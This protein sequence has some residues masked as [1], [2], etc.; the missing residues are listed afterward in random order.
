MRI[1]FGPFAFDPQ[2]RLLWREGVEIALPPRVLGVLEVLLERAG[3]VVA[4]QDLL[5]RVWKDAF[6]TDTSLAE[7][8]SYLRSALGDDPQSPRYI[9]TIH[10]RGYRFLP[11]PTPGP[12]LTPAG[13]GGG[14]RGQTPI[15]GNSLAGEAVTGRL[16]AEEGAKG[17]RAEADWG[18]VPWSIALLCAG[19]AAGA[20][21]YAMRTPAP[22]EPPVARLE[23]TAARGTS[24]DR[25]PQPL[26]ISSDGRSIAWTACETPTGRCGIYVRALDALE[27]RALA[28]TD[29][30]HSPV[31]SPDGRWIAF[32]ADGALKKIAVAGGAPTTLASAPDPAGAAWADEGSIAFAG[33]AAGGL[34]MVNGQGGAVRPLTRVR[35]ERGELRHRNPAWLPDGSLLFTIASAPGAD[36]PGELAAIQPPSNDIRLLRGGITRA[37]PAGRGYLLLAT[38]AD[39]QAAAFDERT[40]ALTGPIDA[41]PAPAADGAPRFA[42]G[43]TALAIVRV[44]AKAELAWSDGVDAGPLGRLTSIAVSSDSRRAAG[45]VIENGG[46]DIWI[47]DLAS[48][49]LTRMTF[50]GTN[51]SPAWSNDGRRIFFAARDGAE[52]FHVVSRDVSDRNAPATR[53]PSAP[54][55]AF[56]SSVAADGRV[57][58]TVYKDERT[59]IVVA[60]PSGGAS[61]AITDGPFEEAAAAFSPD[62]RWLA[63][64]SNESGRTEVIVRSDDGR[65]LPVSTDGGR[66]PRWSEDGRSI[67]FDAGRRL[68]TSA[69][70][71]DESAAVSK[72]SAVIDNAIERAIAVTPSGR[73]LLDRRPPS[74]GAVFV[75]QWLRELR[76]RL[77]L[78]V[79]AP[80]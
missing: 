53:V 25:D 11:T 34:S 28:G 52:P 80:R 49:A 42:A 36:T 56:P 54:S 43:S 26:A 1:S 32:F 21:W 58:L 48:N 45:V 55:Q 7:A 50:G 18:L 59:A 15:V 19:L 60:A 4:R 14:E 29:G 65:R 44:P 20:V 62:G 3:E 74:E 5:D 71:P 12:G 46:A 67:Y 8:V 23:L 64:E 41:V 39:L 31:F 72:P 33:S 51:V 76:E 37:A 79:N 30:G 10:R 24:F 35:P 2:S 9:Q 47:V 66:H 38:D 57:A 68:M 27:P 17:V 13:A 16:P 40:L 61:R 6:V 22:A 78:P 63:L 77:P 69:F 75:L 73:A 70:H